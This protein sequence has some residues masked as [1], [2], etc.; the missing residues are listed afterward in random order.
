[1]Q[2]VKI[3]SR[4]ASAVPVSRGV[5]Q[6]SVLGPVLYSIYVRRIPSILSNVTVIQYA[7]DICF[8]ARGTDTTIL[9]QTLSSSLHDLNSFLQSRSLV[10][11]PD[12]AEVMLVSSA[13]A[14]D[15]S[16]TVKLDGQE[17]KQVNCA[18]Y[19]GL[20]I[21]SHLTFS[22][23]VE[24]VVAKLAGP[25]FAL[26]RHRHKLDMKSRRM[27]YLTLIQPHLEYA[28]NAFCNL[29]SS[30]LINMLSVAANNAIR[31]IFGLPD[32]VHVT[33]L[34]Q[35]LCIAPLHQRYMLKCYIAA[36]KCANGL[37]PAPLAD[38]FLLN[39]RQ[40]NLTRQ[41]TFCTFKLPQVSSQIGLNSLSF[42]AADR[43]N[44]LPAD[45]RSAPNLLHFTSQLK[46]FIGYPRREGS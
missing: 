32:W 23:H 31:A 6:G 17:I 26:R 18:R 42:L 5:P 36:Y 7:D 44:G 35:K 41:N 33:P 9:S 45:L 34:Y 46:V 22:Y 10:L 27:Y 25:T 13:R 39:K 4:I 20:Y 38:R 2:A 15:R 37:A 3:G 30:Q 11:N 43:F 19:L 24:K 21:D 28:S 16:L 1:M 29:L 40:S 12:K 8:F 14:Q